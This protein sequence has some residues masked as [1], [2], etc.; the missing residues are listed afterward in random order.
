MRTVAGSAHAKTREA[1]LGPLPG[2]RS[3]DNTQPLERHSQPSGRLRSRT[4]PEICHILGLGTRYPPPPTHTHLTSQPPSDS[5]HHFPIIT[6][7]AASPL[8]PTAPRTQRQRSPHAQDACL[9]AGN[10]LRVGE[11]GGTRR[12][13]LGWSGKDGGQEEL[14]TVR[15][16]CRRTRR[17]RLPGDVAMDMS[18]PERL[19]AHNLSATDC[20][21]A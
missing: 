11:W 8:P 18:R 17:R 9:P 7:A 16:V 3:M 6:T 4:R 15:G 21:L 5:A 19:R 14:A 10:D 13:G 1:A 12:R 20:V 2:L